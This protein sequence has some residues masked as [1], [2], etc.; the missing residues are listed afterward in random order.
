MAQQKYRLILPGSGIIPTSRIA[1][2]A[3]PG[4][5]PM[6]F[7]LVFAVIALVLDLLH[8]V[9]R[10]RRDLAVEV[11]ALRQHVRMYQRQAKQAPRLTRWDKVVLAAI[12]TRY[13]TLAS[14]VVIVRPA[15]V[16]R[17]HRELA[18]CSVSQIVVGMVG[19]W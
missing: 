14:A 9:T 18:K 13:R 12:I 10:D 7:A 2:Y 19:V 1:P 5:Y 6:P 3:P 17:W 15:T 11:V 8:A 16:L 4:R